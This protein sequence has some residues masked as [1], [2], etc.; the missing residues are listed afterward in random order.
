VGNL[1]VRTRYNYDMKVILTR[2]RLWWREFV[3]KHIVAEYP[4]EDDL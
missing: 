1:P 2:I 4:Y 3:R